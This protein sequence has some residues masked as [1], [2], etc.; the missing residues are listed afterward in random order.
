MKYKAIIMDVDGTCVTNAIDAKPTKK[1]LS[2]IT[3]AQKKIPVCLSTARPIS[4]ARRVINELGIVDPCAIADSTV[5]YD[6]KTDSII[7]SFPMDHKIAEIVKKHL[8]A[9]NLSFMVGEEHAEN[10]YKEG[11]LPEKILGF[12]VFEITQAVADDLITSLTHIPNIAAIKVHSY[13]PGLFWVTI[14]SQVAT[15]LHSVIELSKIIGVD[16]SYVIGIGD[17]YNDFPLL[18]ACG[19]KIAMGNAVPELKAIAD[20]I[21]P[22]VEEDGV[23]TI[24]EKFILND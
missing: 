3:L 4:I 2:A 22:S 7:K 9:R 6:P 15:K 24:I 12:A 13:K 14:T 20:F 8:L 5:I 11:G 10:I 16:P 19:L 21:A 1:V 18:E 23:A 17:G